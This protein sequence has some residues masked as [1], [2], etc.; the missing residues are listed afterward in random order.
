MRAR[1][2]RSLKAIWYRDR[3]PPLVLRG[4]SRVYS[5]YV[6]NRL[7][8]PTRMPPVPVIVVGNLTAGGSG[9][10]PVVA[11]LVRMF[12]QSGLQPAVLSRGYGGTEPDS[13]MAVQPSSRASEVG[14]EALELHRAVGC[15][16]WVCRFRARALDAA[17]AA[18]ADVIV[19]DDGLQHVALPRSF[20]ICVIDGRRGFG[21]GWSLPAGPLRQDPSRLEQVDLVLVKQGKGDPPPEPPALGFMLESTGLQPFDPSQEDEPLPAPGRRVDALAGIADPASFFRQLEQAGYALR[22][23]SLVDHEPVDPAWLASLAGPV[24]MTAKDA[25]RI[26]QAARSDLFVWP[27]VARLPDEALRRVLDHVREFNA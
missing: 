16:V 24:V 3:P 17:V 5:G 18:G 7:V 23:H 9:K 12:Q 22:C 20:E 27:V 10:T 25:A 2:A 15:A 26:G 19:S 8:R 14:D 21:N 13:A 4:L 1:L 11:A 6:R